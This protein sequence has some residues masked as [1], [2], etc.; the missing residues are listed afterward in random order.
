[1][2]DYQSKFTGAEIDSRLEQ[3]GT[4]VQPAALEGKQDKLVSGENIKTVGGQSILGSGDIPIQAGDTNAVQYVAQELT[5][6]QKQQARAN[7]N[8]ASLAD[9]EDMDYVTADTRPE[10]SA[11]TM[12]HLYLIGPDADNNYDRYYTQESNGTYSWVPLGSTQLN[13]STYATK[14]EVSQLRQEVTADVSQLEAKV[15]DKIDSFHEERT[16][17]DYSEVLIDADGK[18]LESRDA[19]GAKTEYT[20]V[21]MKKDLSVEKDLL[22]KESATVKE[23]LSVEGE[24]GAETSD[25]AGEKSNPVESAKYVKVIVDGGDKIVAGIEKDGTVY[26]PKLRAGNDVL[27][28]KKWA[29]CGDSFTNGSASLPTIPG[30]LYAGKKQTYGWLIGHRCNMVIQHMAIGGRTIATP[31]NLSVHNCFTDLASALNYSQIAA[32]VDYITLYFGINDAGNAPSGESGDGE[33]PVGEIPFGELTD[34]TP[35]T[36]CGAWNY[37]LPLLITN[38]P[39]AHIG[40]LVSNGITSFGTTYSDATK[41]LANK[42]GI[43]WIDL[44]GDRHT[45]FMI[46][47]NNPLIPQ[48]VK[49][50]RNIEQAVEW[51]VDNHPNAQAHLYESYFIEQF[52]RSI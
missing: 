16:R 48:S 17:Q 10:A 14:D 29:V 11:S 22:V 44:N 50:A 52:L 36:F 5:E 6:E 39:F 32:D 21:T 47:S 20:E 3:A 12:G 1:M 8:A 2:A 30:G 33:T 19:T 38:H 27:S 43:P 34:T 26:I 42:W 9:I 35:N 40:I 49:D 24:I 45:P 51:G 25:I 7:I 15:T 31:A 23:N 28:G 4:A 18:M 13:L 37:V 46:R 41:A